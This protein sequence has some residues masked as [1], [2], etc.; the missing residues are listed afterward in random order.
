V[1]VLVVVVRDVT[2]GLVILRVHLEIIVI[3]P[4][5]LLHPLAGFHWLDQQVNSPFALWP[6]C[7]LHRLDLYQ[8]RALINF[9]KLKSRLDARVVDNR[10]L[11]AQKL[12]RVVHISFV[13]LTH[14]DFSPR[15]L[16]INLLNLQ[17]HW[18]LCHSSIHCLN[19]N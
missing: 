18:N 10:Q 3:F 8:A 4:L 17:N 9:L 1:V 2:E 16:T 7:E 5:D 11:L 14:V 19:K 12:V 6:Q 13:N 15:K